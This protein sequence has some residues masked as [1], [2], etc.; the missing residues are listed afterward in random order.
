MGPCNP[1]GTAIEALRGKRVTV[2]SAFMIK[3][4]NEALALL[5]E[6]EKEPYTLEYGAIIAAAK[7]DK[8][9]KA[10]CPRIRSDLVTIGIM[11]F[12]RQ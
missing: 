12:E 1:A 10:R 6:H 11:E 4:A 3:D 7:A 8:L 2:R 9:R 5:H